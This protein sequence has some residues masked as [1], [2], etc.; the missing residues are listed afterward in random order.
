MLTVADFGR[1]VG[2]EL[3][4]M[5]DGER[6]GRKSGGALTKHVGCRNSTAMTRAGGLASLGAGERVLCLRAWGQ[7]GQWVQSVGMWEA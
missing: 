3:L 5:A 7:G 6:V 1:T 2:F 4:V